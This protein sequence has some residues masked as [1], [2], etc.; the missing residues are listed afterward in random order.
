MPR[1]SGASILTLGLCRLAQIQIPNKAL[2][3]RDCGSQLLKC[4]LLITC[5]L[6]IKYHSPVH[7]PSPHKS[8]SIW[9]RLYDCTGRAS[10]RVVQTLQ[11]E[12]NEWKKK[13]TFLIAFY[14]KICFHWFNSDQIGSFFEIEI[15]FFVAR[16]SRGMIL[17]L[18]AR[19]PGFKSRTSPL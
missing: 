2:T 14:L 16:W 6:N 5:L 11:R 1:W 9:G 18:G 10:P 12:T 15:N 4:G 19:G 17:A 7:S 3:K 13:S 8:L